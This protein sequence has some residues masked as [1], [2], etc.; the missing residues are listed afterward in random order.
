MKLLTERLKRPIPE[1][2]AARAKVVEFAKLVAL[3]RLPPSRSTFMAA[4]GISRPIDGVDI[5]GERPF[6]WTGFVNTFLAAGMGWLMKMNAKNKRQERLADMLY[7]VAQGA[8]MGEIG[9][10]A[11]AD[12][13]E[14]PEV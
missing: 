5:V 11:M 4:E 13:G 14:D 8:L 3:R 2:A 12:A 1:T 7:G 6:E 10:R 9:R